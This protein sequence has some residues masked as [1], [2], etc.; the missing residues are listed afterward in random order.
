MTNAKIYIPSVVSG[1]VV[2]CGGASAAATALVNITGAPADPGGQGQASGLVEFASGAVPDLNRWGDLI[3][4]AAGPELVPPV[5]DPG[6]NVALIGPPRRGGPLG[7]SDQGPL[8]S[9]DLRA[10][11]SWEIEILPHSDQNRPDDDYK[12][13]YP[14]FGGP[15]LLPPN[16]REGL[17]FSNASAIPG[18]GPAVM[19]IVSGAIAL[20]RR[21]RR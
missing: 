5:D 4:P 1:I 21:R 9:R 15:G 7:H 3:D 14:G 10:A 18:P 16:S 13:R 19:L 17:G 2:T 11:D 6:P 12:P 20:G 8:S